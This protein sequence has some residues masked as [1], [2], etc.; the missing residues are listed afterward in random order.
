MN[1]NFLI[2]AVMLAAVCFGASSFLSIRAQVPEST[3]NESYTSDRSAYPPENARV[4]GTKYDDIGIRSENSSHGE[5]NLPGK[6]SQ[7]SEN[8]SNNNSSNPSLIQAEV[9][10]IPVQTFENGRTTLTYKTV[11]TYRTSDGVRYD[12]KDTAQAAGKALGLMQDYHRTTNGTEKAKLRAELV[13]LTKQQFDAMQ[14]ARMKEVEKLEQ[15]LQE[16]KTQLDQRTEVKDKI[17]ERRVEQLLGTDPIY[18]WDQ[19]QAAQ[20]GFTPPNSSNT[21]IRFYPVDAPRGL[22]GQGAPLARLEPTYLPLAP[23]ESSRAYGY[24]YNEVNGLNPQTFVANNSNRVAMEKTIADL[25]KQLESSENEDLKKV[26]LESI[27]VL[28]TQLSILNA[29]P[30]LPQLP[31]NMQR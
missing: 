21:S 18:Q 26:L 14:M 24:S 1:K 8:K 25:N 16:A 10:Q 20:I 4:L 13:K 27:K 6:A 3:Q 5:T 29:L 31:P 17:V 7:S 28:E 15:E 9:T 23:R 22:P 19:R 12:D 2:Y 11:T 30:P